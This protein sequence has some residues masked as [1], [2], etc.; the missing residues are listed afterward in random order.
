MTSTP[1]TFSRRRLGLVLG[2]VLAVLAAV[3]VADRFGPPGTGLVA[4]PLVALG[5]VLLA[6]RAGLSWWEL[7]LSRH[8]FLSGLRYA[9]GAVLAVALVYAVGAAVPLTRPAFLD[10]RY[11]LHVGAALVAAFVVVPLGTVLLEEV[12]FRGVLLGLVHRHRGAAWAS[13]T[14]SVLFG[15]WHIL[16]SL[17]LSRANHAVGV[18]L[19]GGVLPV[20]AAVGFTALAGLLLCELRRR[21]GS[22]LAAAALYWATNGLGVLLAAALFRLGTAG[23]ML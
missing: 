11:H 22:L 1:E 15:L 19:G 23:A 2:A 8:T 20:L 21:S 14:S 16:P 4:G 13:V 5:L 10:V 7:G 17:G 6:R 12:A 18:V 9:V 3:N